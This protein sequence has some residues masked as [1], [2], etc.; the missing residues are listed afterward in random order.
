MQGAKGKGLIRSPLLH[1]IRSP[2]QLSKISASPLSL[3]IQTSVVSSV[4]VS[5]VGVGVGSSVV[6]STVNVVDSESELVS[7]SVV[8]IA[9]TILVRSI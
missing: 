2:S 4:L 6:L 5:V 7:V 1:S 8:C 3:E 9:N